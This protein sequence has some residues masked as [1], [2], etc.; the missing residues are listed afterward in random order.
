M[1]ESIGG[2]GSIGFI[3]TEFEIKTLI[4]YVLRRLPAPISSDELAQLV[5]IDGGF[6]YFDYAECLASLVERG[7]VE[8]T[9][10]KYSIT[11]AG[12]S[13]A[14]TLS[15]M[16]P[17]SVQQKAKRASAP[18]AEKMRRSSG[19]SASIERTR[20]GYVLSLSLSDG[21]NELFRSAI[22]LSTSE[23]AEALRA[24][25]LQDPYGARR[26][27]ISAIVETD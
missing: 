14:D 27:I 22:Q 20:E 2:F 24:A 11:A 19:A 25:F 5:M 8:E 13:A 3:R 16:L 17:A 7:S 10:S 1:N 6:G 26:R 23:E 4:L 15:G 12:I 18:V 21:G 9:D